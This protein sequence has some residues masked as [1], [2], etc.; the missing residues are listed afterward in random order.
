MSTL[1]RRYRVTVDGAAHDIVTSA[2]DYAAIEVEPD[3]RPGA[4]Q[5]WAMLHA[6]FIRL[7]VPGI[8]HDLGKFVDL[9]DDVEDLDGV[10]VG[11]PAENPTQPVG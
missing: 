5:T 7:E 1:R 2:R 6:A 8:P 9:L 11:V 4:E 3:A 10:P